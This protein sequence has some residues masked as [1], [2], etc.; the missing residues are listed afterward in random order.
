[1]TAV[2]N[3][4]SKS[5]GFPG[6]MNNLPSF[7]PRPISGTVIKLGLVVIVAEKVFF[8]RYRLLLKL[9]FENVC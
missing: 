1:M 7:Q 5:S 6:K 8:V 4:L 3:R 9:K 2:K